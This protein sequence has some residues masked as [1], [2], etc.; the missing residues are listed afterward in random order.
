MARPRRGRGHQDGYFFG[1]GHDYAQGLADLRTLTG[2]AVLLP[3]WAFGAWYSRYFA[4]RAA[5]YRR[6]VLPAFRAHRVPLDVLVV[7]TDWKSPDR[8]AGW[9]WNP[10]LFPDPGGFLGWAAR[11]ELRVVLNVHPA[12]SE[13]DPRYPEAQALAG[14]RLAPAARSHAPAARRFDWGDPAQA[15][16]WAALHAPFERLGVAQW[17]LDHCCEDSRVSLPGLTADSWVN[18]LYRRRGE[19]RGLRGFVLSRIGASFPG[20]RTPGASGPWAEHRS[21]IHFTGDA[22]SDWATLAFAAAMTPAE[23]SIGQPYVSH[24]IGGFARR[25]LPDDLYLRWVQLGAFQ[26]ILRLHSDHGDRLPWDYPPAV[27]RAASAFLRLRESLVPYLYAVARAAHDTGLPMARA[28]YLHWPRH[29]AAYGHPGE[30]MLG[31]ALLVAPVTRPGLVSTAKVWFP[32]GT[33]TNLFTGAAFRGPRERTVTATTRDMPVYARA[34]AILP[35]APAAPNVDSQPQDELSLTVHPGGSGRTALYDDAGEGLGYRR[36]AFARTP[37]R[38]VDRRGGCRGGRST[39]AIGPVRGGYRGHPRRRT[40][41]VVFA[42]VGRPCT[43]RV[44]GRGAAY[45]YRPASRRL[46][47]RVT[48]G[49]GR[50][51]V[52]HDAARLPTR[53]RGRLIV[54]PQR[55]GEDVG[56]RRPRAQ[57]RRQTAGS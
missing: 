13:G 3:K 18:E 36:G 21:T 53:S 15:R 16:A 54:G 29:A 45:T 42:G 1:Y 35:R 31:D 19:A 32:P 55:G 33:W 56:S 26:P 25:H 37:V 23:G 30:Y 22:R 39:L 44:D 48:A 43:V 27:R 8:W 52:A 11:E 12:I 9:S 5:D 57:S 7:D 14:G 4:H 40:Y 49:R 46:V 34:G 51:A 20:Y 47:V 41:T 38:Y 6:R 10:A 2:P 28:L 17:W 24:D 50:L